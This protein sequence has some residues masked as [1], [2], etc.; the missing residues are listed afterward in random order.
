MKKSCMKPNI[1]KRPTNMSIVDVNFKA[2][3]SEEKFDIEP[4][5]P[6]PGPTLLIHAIEAVNPV[7]RSQPN[8]V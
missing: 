5:S 1:S 8:I 2:P 7:S 6:K 3:G 4:T